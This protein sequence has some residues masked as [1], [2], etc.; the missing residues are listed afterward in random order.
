MRTWS[1]DKKET[2]HAG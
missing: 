1:S 2:G